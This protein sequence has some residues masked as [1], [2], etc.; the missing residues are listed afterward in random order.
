MIKRSREAKIP[1]RMSAMAIGVE[2]VMK[3]KHSR[4]LFP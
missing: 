4:G 1:H 2:R 3:A